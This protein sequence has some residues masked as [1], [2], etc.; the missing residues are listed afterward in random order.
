MN[1][2]SEKKSLVVKETSLEGVKV[3]IPPTVFNDFRGDY[4]ETYNK[5]LYTEAGIVAEFIQDDYAT[6]HQHVL[7]GIHGDDATA[8][9]I[10][11]IYGSLYVIIVNNN[12]ASPQYKQWASFDLSCRNKIQI[13]V[14]EK[15]GTSY[16]VVSKKAIF[17]YKQTEYYNDNQFTIKW[18]DPEYNFWWPIDNP[19]TSKRDSAK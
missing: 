5:E 15:F 17:H 3:V 4:V 9:L 11:C 2:L 19:I 8:K 12:P 7:R 18:N 6:S 16:L 10:D 14:P 13:F 1:I